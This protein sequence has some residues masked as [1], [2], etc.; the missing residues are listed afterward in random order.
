MSEKTGRSQDPAVPPVSLLLTF[1]FAQ[2]AQCWDLGV[3][4]AAQEHDQYNAP[5]LGRAA[6]VRSATS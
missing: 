2:E 4:A 5:G 1:L 6:R 3:A